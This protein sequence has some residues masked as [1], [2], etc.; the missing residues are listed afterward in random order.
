MTV[1]GSESLSLTH[2]RE[3]FYFR[4]FH[5]FADLTAALIA[6]SARNF[7]LAAIRSFMASD[8]FT[9]R[10]NSSNDDVSRRV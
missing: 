4:F 2:A 1:R 9:S 3:I 7:S 5:R 8:C 10:Q 6:R